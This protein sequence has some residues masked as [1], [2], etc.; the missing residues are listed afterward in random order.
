[1]ATANCNCSKCNDNPSRCGCG[2]KAKTNPCTYTDCTVGSER[3]G[4]V[5]DAACVT[6]GGQSFTIGQA[7]ALLAID[8]GERLDS[9]IQKFAN[10]I[11][12]NL[13]ACNSDDVNHNPFNVYIT[14]IKKDEATVVW[15]GVSN[16]SSGT[17]VYVDTQSSSSGW[18]LVNSTPVALTTFTQK[19]TGLTADTAYKVKVETSSPPSGCKVMEV[20]FKTLAS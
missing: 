16:T 12:N 15:N 2:D 10:M 4:D 3:C 11:S 20:L 6:Y 9:I 18:T 14:N 1:M 13:G 19:I 7:N 8:S 5:Q 17:N